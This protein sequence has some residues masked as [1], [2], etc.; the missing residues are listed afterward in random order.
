MN[1]DQTFS[2]NEPLLF[3]CHFLAWDAAL[4][5]SSSQDDEDEDG[6]GK[7]EGI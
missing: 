7:E 2:E 5:F 3:K 6:Y 1:I 4:I